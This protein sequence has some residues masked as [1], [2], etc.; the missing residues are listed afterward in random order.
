M[1]VDFLAFNSN[2]S[3]IASP[4]ETSGV[5]LVISEASFI[6]SLAHTSMNQGYTDL[7]APRKEERI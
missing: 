2:H 7:S 5:H 3:L 1:E 6:V 4:V